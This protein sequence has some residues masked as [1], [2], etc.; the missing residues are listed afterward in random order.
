[1]YTQ[2]ETQELE[3]IY[4]GFLLFTKFSIRLSDPTLAIFATAFLY[5]MFGQHHRPINILT[6]ICAQPSVSISWVFSNSNL[7][8]WF[9]IKTDNQAGG[10]ASLRNIRRLQV[11]RQVGSAAG[12][13][14]FHSSLCLKCSAISYCYFD[15][16][17][18]SLVLTYLASPNVVFYHCQYQENL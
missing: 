18:L 14:S 6:Y 2:G 17:N 11:S 9:Q 15:L 4:S 3:W 8:F 7:C 1:M 5:I 16:W 12:A 10:E 13:V